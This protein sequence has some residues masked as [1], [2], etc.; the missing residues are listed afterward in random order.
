M[1]THHYRDISLLLPPAFA[2]VMFLQVCVCPQGEGGRAW[3]ILR[4]TVN[5]EVVRILLECILVEIMLMLLEK[6]RYSAMIMSHS[7]QCVI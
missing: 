3:Q 2:K 1:E 4:D 5:E 7:L 6:Y